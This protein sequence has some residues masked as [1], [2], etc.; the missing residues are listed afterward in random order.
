MICASIGLAIG[1]VLGCWLCPTDRRV[2]VLRDCARLDDGRRV[3]AFTCRMR[4][5]A[6]GRPGEW[7]LK[8]TK[9]SQLGT[10]SVAWLDRTYG[11]LEWYRARFERPTPTPTPNPVQEEGDE[12]SCP[13]PQPQ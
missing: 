11:A 7:S 4:V 3:I 9:Y 13:S 10:E 5:V 6:I 12:Q 2:R 8:T 1:L